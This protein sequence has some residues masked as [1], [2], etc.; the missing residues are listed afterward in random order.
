[1][2]KLEL[3]NI[4]LSILDNQIFD[5]T[6]PC[7]ELGLLNSFFEP[8]FF[9]AVSAFDY[10]FLTKRV[11][12][13]ESS[14]RV[15][16]E[17]LNETYRDFLY[18]YDLPLDCQRVFRIGED[19]ISS[20]TV[21]FGAVWCN[22]EDPV[23]EYIGNDLEID[24]EGEYTAPKPFLFLVAYQLAIHI[25]PFITPDGDGMKIAAQMYQ[26]TL[27]SIISTEARNNDVPYDHGAVEQW[28]D[29][30]DFDF[31]QYRRDLYKG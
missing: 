17:G 6:T 11:T 28:G 21:R 24:A 14:L 13:D 30:Q 2:N 15:D 20:Y 22:I 19:D 25:A 18:G 9:V 29:E 3:Y 8:A 23:I 31:L 27:S 1:M 5:L 12:L 10:P 16:S 7:K 26:L 4:A